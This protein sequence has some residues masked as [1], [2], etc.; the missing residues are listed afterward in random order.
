M[1]WKCDRGMKN[2]YSNLSSMKIVY[3]YP[4]ELGKMENRVRIQAYI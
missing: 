3:S 2:T 1:L 4:F